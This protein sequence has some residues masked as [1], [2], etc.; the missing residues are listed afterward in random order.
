RDFRHS[1]VIETDLLPQGA[2]RWLHRQA[3][4]LSQRHQRALASISADA[5][6]ER[7]EAVTPARRETCRVTDLAPELVQ[8]EVDCA[9][10]ALLVLADAYYPGWSARF[11]EQAAGNNSESAATA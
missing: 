2:K 4:T 9:R 11:I 7:Q 1:A 8:L 5:R 3:E 10:P 6:K